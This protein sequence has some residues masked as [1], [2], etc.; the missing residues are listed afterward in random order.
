[1]PRSEGLGFRWTR[2][3]GPL[4]FLLWEVGDVAEDVATGWPER[5][6]LKYMGLRAVLSVSYQTWLAQAHCSHHYIVCGVF[7][8][9]LVTV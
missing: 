5:V 6:P 3:L 8:L 7:A 1:M 2:T 9:S 4:N